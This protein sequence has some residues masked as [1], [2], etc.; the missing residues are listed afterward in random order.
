MLDYVM[1]KI[2][3]RMAIYDRSAAVTMRNKRPLFSFSFDD[4]PVSAAKNGARILEEHGARG[5]FYLAGSLIGQNVWGLEM[6]KDGDIE[7]VV[8]AGHEIGCHSFSHQAVEDMSSEAIR[9]DIARNAEVLRRFGVE[10]RS[11]A[12]PF[13]I[14][15]HSAKRQLSGLFDT[16]R[17]VRPGFASGTCDPGLIE[18]VALY[19]INTEIESVFARIEAT[20]IKGGWLN[21]FTHDVHES[22]SEIGCRPSFLSAIVGRIKDRGGAIVPVGSAFREVKGD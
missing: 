2:S 15:S 16:C 7:T 6:V 18:A 19:E 9:D 4:F 11:F 14:F 12:Y 17:C 10:A 21:L 13:G 20:L 5:T 3:R 22:P 8:A 1:K